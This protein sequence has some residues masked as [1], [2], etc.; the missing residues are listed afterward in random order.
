M[1][2]LRVIQIIL[3]IMFLAVS[4][5]PLPVIHEAG[6]TYRTPITITEQ[7]GTDLYNYSI[8]IILN[9]TNFDGWNNILYENGSD[10]YFLDNSGNPLYYWIESFNKTEQQATIWVRVPS[11]PASS[12]I[13]IY[14]YYG[15][16]NDYPDYNDPAQVFPFYDDFNGDSL[17]TSK[18]KIN[19]P[20]DGSVSVSNSELS[21]ISKD[22]QTSPTVQSLQSF[23]GN[24]IVEFKGRVEGDQYD[25]LLIGLFVSDGSKVI[26]DNPSSGSW[27]AIAIA[28][29][30]YSTDYVIYKCINDEHSELSDKDIG[31]F[32][33]SIYHVYGIAWYNGV[34]Y[35]YIEY[36]K[37]TSVSDSD[38]SSGYIAIGS[39]DNEGYKYVDW[40]R[41][42][43]YVDPEPSVSI[44]SSEALGGVSIEGVSPSSVYA[45]TGDT[46]SFE[47]MLNNTYS[48][49]V[50]VT[51]KL[52]DHDSIVRDEVNATVP[53][54]NTYNVSLSTVLTENDIGDHTW[55]ISVY[56]ASDNSLLDSCSISVSVFNRTIEITAV[57]PSSISGEPNDTVTV[58]VTVKSTL[59][60]TVTVNISLIDHNDV[61][62]DYV[63]TAIDPGQV[64]TV[65][66]STTLAEEDRGEWVWRVRVYN[67][68]TT[69]SSHSLNASIH[70]SLSYSFSY[71]LQPSASLTQSEIETNGYT[72]SLQPLSSLNVSEVD[73]YTPYPMIWGTKYC[74]DLYTNNTG[75]WSLEYHECG[76]Y[77]YVLYINI[78]YIIESPYP[79]LVY[80]YISIRDND[81]DQIVTYMYI[82]HGNTSRTVFSDKYYTLEI[83][84]NGTTPHGY[85]YELV[86]YVVD[87]V[88]NPDIIYVDN[89]KT[90]DIY[91]RIYEEETGGN[92]GGNGGDGGSGDGEDS[93]PPQE[94]F[95]PPPPVSFGEVDVSGVL[96][97]VFSVG[98]PSLYSPHGIL[99]L[100]FFIG[101]FIVYSRELSWGQALVLAS[102]L[103]MII[104]VILVGI[105]L[106]PLF[107]VLF[108]VGIGMWKILGK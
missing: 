47:V 92:D 2:C 94:S 10:V 27:Y 25:W 64:L 53:A 100:A 9:S 57:D 89:D 78:Y 88:E 49:D 1:G 17:D 84:L 26:N 46:V 73:T 54:N 107:M 62:R 106:V 18:W 13:T 96:P 40:I 80:N 56:N 31:D 39:K 41:V 67:E 59:L 98:S 3:L 104:S 12:S 7:S 72:Y 83:P 6:G 42:R 20:D 93:T 95:S 28:S 22:T 29:N 101:L 75:D 102:G 87:G 103:S 30:Y 58:N 70:Y 90:I 32:D 8:K 24:I 44:G 21:I 105:T 34:I 51:V 97:P 55:T 4:I 91:F 82:P 35:P 23:S 15:G 52:I 11:I 81:T 61:V 69:F 48:Y 14:M 68:T 77:V 5:P 45:G 108:I 36:T 63:E 19:Y 86:K 79:D 99:V 37:Y 66:L 60:W 65:S 43:E 71:T 85:K 76:A 38:L 50:D 16:T 74:L 33:K